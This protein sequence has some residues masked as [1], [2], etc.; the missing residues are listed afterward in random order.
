MGTA[1]GYKS[2][3]LLDFEPSFGTDP[4][5]PDARL[6]PINSLTLSSSRAKNRPNTR[7]GHRNPAPPF[8]GNIEASGS[9][10]VPVDA[11]AFAYWLKAMFGS[12][13]TTGTSTPYTHK[14]TVGDIQPSLVIEHKF[15]DASAA[16]AYAKFNG[17][18]I[19]SWSLEFGGD[20]EVVSS[21]EI[22]GADENINDVAY[23][24]GPVEPSFQRFQMFQAQIKEGGSTSAIITEGDFT[25]NFGLDADTARPVGNNGR[26]S[27]IFEGI[28]EASGNITALFQD[29]TLIDKAI[30]ST[31]TSI[32]LGFTNGDLEIWITFNE[33]QLERNTPEVSGP[34]G[35]TLSLP[36][37]AYYDDATDVSVVVVELTNNNDGA[38]Y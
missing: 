28:L 29:R 14:F 33:V 32:A 19:G 6:M 17:C 27:D 37:Q 1:R 24:S 38:D 11:E 8:D 23:D 9:L 20:G 35:V 21:F 22:L 5:T 25:V 30:N 10:E 2:T 7:R 16:I 34:Q 4:E 12:P 26:L 31:E 3:C 36:W 18:K 13:T 15:A